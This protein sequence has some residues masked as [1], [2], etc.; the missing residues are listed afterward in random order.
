[1]LQLRA[2]RRDVPGQVAEGGCCSKDGARVD[3]DPLLQSMELFVP[4]AIHRPF[5][6]P[7]GGPNGQ[8]LE[9]EVH[10]VLASTVGP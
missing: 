9:N 6:I 2:R 4:I 5:A 10:V 8:L 7:K 1:M 3:D